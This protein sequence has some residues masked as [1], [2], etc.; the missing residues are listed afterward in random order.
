MVSR[1]ERRKLS[2]SALFEATLKA[3]LGFLG[4]KGASMVMSHHDSHGLPEAWDSLVRFQQ[5]SNARS[6][7]YDEAQ[8]MFDSHWGLGNCEAV[9]DRRFPHVVGT[10]VAV[11]G[12]RRSETVAR[13]LIAP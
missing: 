1:A 11:P 10:V 7:C 3:T 8:A 5:E 4:K 2:S 9:S 12:R 13:L 6:S